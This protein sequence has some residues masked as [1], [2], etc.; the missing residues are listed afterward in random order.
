MVW[1]TSLFSGTL[2]VSM[3]DLISFLATMGY[4]CN[5]GDYEVVTNFPNRTI[6]SLNLTSTFREAGLHPRSTLFIQAI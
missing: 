2:L 4:D 6:S 1:C 3:Q 5:Q